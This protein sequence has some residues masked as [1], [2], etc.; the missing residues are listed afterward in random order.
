MKVFASVGGPC[1]L[2]LPGG[3]TPPPQPSDLSLHRL[4]MGRPQG[5]LN[6]RKYVTDSEG[7]PVATLAVEQWDSPG[8]GSAHNRIQ[9]S[10][11]Q[12]IFAPT[13]APRLPNSPPC[14]AR[15]R[16]SNRFTSRSRTSA[17]TPPPP[18]EPSPAPSPP[19]PPPRPAPRTPAPPRATWREPPS[20][21]RSPH[22]AGPDRARPPLP[23]IARR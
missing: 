9:P 6:R 23:S 16:R 13:F 17:P 20:P 21:A 7:R 22:T 19:P 1:G 3:Q 18:A 11:R 8:R 2:R 14:R 15:W 4:R 5:E 10:G 12:V